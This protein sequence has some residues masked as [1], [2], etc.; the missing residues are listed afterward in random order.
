MKR[1]FYFIAVMTAALAIVLLH[2]PAEAEEGMW[3][4]DNLPLK[5]FKSLYAFEPSKEWIDH[6]RLSS[7]KFKNGS[8]SFISATGLALTNHHV[9]RGELQKLSTPDRDYVKDGFY[10]PSM[11]KELK[12]PDME[13]RVLAGF[14]DVTGRIV[15]A[16]Q[17]LG[18]KESAAA[19]KKLIA[20]MEKEHFE[21]TGNKAEIVT[22]YHGGEYWLYSYK[23]CRDVRLVFAPENQAAHFGGS[24]DN[25]TYPRY[26]LDFAIFRV[27][28]NGKPA[29]IK[30]FFPV[31]PA[32]VKKDELVFTVGHP[33]T[34]SRQLTAAQVVF[35]RDVYYP[36]ALEHTRRAIKVLEDYSAK[37]PEQRRQAFAQKS[38]LENSLK[39]A[40]GE[41]P[42][43]TSD[44][45]TA[46]FLSQEKALRAD[47]AKKPE[48]RKETGDPWKAIEQTTAGYRE[49]FKPMYYL[50]KENRMLS[51]ALQLV[52]L[53]EETKKPDSERLAAYRSSKLEGLKDE[54]LSKAPVYRDLEKAQLAD[55]LAEVKEYVGRDHPYV[56]LLL[57][58]KTPE[59]RAA[60]LIAGTALD[61]VDVRK[62]LLEGGSLSI[63]RSGDTLIALARKLA[64]LRREM[65]LW[66]E[67]N[68]TEALA[69]QHELIAHAR[70]EL[71]GKSVYPDG[72]STLRMAYGTV[73]GYPYNGTLCPPVTTFFGMYDRYYSFMEK[74]G[75]WAL[76]ER[77]IERQGALRLSTQLDFANTCD[78]TGGNS[79]SPVINRKGEIVG[80]NFDSN[81]EG[82]YGR[83]I[84]H[85]ETK[86]AI[87]LSMAG[88]VE[89]LRS[90][91]GAGKLADEL[92]GCVQGK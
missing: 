51:Q 43:I 48:L 44:K 86:R 16:S 77:L 70:F 8:G 33:G 65:I 1:L 18:L 9:V 19:R 61:R 28:D 72:T 14:E 45:T 10:A 42:G 11:D 84:Y 23:T 79:G 90:V 37:G 24:F 87:A 15:K 31:N 83:Y 56:M 17:N 30:D 62:E 75:E 32:G 82:Q 59:A 74:E 66:G 35:L 3:T 53:A 64:P 6:V 5:A 63:G 40:E 85:Y 80:L 54:L 27:Y 26:A 81:M 47:L 88:M 7:I 38:S 21:K 50:F 92:T 58:G 25:F 91:Y 22:L 73:K 67:E 89:V 78:T 69:S 41:Y 39:R 12:C 76:P 29:V 46:S 57:D 55:Y 2:G 36:A 60:E 71:Y 52:M 20:E 34:T 68:Y 49:R 13:L 4:F